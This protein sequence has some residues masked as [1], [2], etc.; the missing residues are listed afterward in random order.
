MVGENTEELYDL[1]LTFKK[2]T[3]YMK[4]DVKT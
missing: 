2:L 1:E 3:I 4:K